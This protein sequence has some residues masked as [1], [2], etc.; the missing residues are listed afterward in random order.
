VTENGRELHSAHEV[1]IPG[2]TE[3]RFFEEAP[4]QGF[5]EFKD[6]E[7]IM[8]SPVGIP[9]QRIV[10]FLGSLLR[11]HVESKDLGEVFTGPAVLRLR[12]NLDREPDLFF[13]SRARRGQVTEQHV[14]APVDLIVEVTSPGSESRD[15]EEK[16]EE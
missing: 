14:R 8:H 4:E 9:H 12:E 1:R 6:G 13:L 10:G 7:L 2:W 15:L 3:P 16:R 11:N 5:F